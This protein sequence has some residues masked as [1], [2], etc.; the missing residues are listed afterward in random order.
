MTCGDNGK[1]LVMNSR[2]TYRILNSLA[3]LRY[4]KH[5]KFSNV[6]SQIKSCCLE[7][8]KV[9]RTDYT[10]ELRK[11]FLIV[12]NLL[13]LICAPFCLAI[14]QIAFLNESMDYLFLI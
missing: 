5:L 7:F 11:T 3:R 1:M 8:V 13:T 9:V 2:I 10:I 6:Q 14:L 12:N 4:I